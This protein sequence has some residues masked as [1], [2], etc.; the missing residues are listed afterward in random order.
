M[1]VVLAKLGNPE[2]V[3]RFALAFAVTAPVIMFA[4]LQLRA[5]QAT[6][7]KEDYSFGQYFALRIV[8]AVVALLVIAGIAAFSGY[9]REAVWV[10]AAVGLAKTFESISDVIHG[11]AQQHERM[12]RIAISLSIKG[13]ISLLALGAVTYLT[14]SLVAGCLALAAAW[15]TVL[16]VYDLRI[17]PDMLVGRH[18]SRRTRRSTLRP[19]WNAH[20]LWRLAFLSLPL[21]LTMMLISL[22]ANIPRYFVEGFRGERQLGIFAAMS[23]LMVAGNTVVAALGQSASPRMAHH[24][25]DRDKKAFTLL[26]AR[27][28]GMGAVV[29]IAGMLVAAVAGRWLLTVFYSAEYAREI[30]AFVWI[31]AATGLSYVQSFLGCAMTA[32]RCF[33]VQ[34]PLLGASALVTAGLCYFLVHAWGILGAAIAIASATGALT[35]G[36]L[37]IVLLAIRRM[38]DGGRSGD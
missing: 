12:N 8:T 37:L 24:F 10:I 17:V 20:V 30:G 32:T 23:Y 3:G 9:Q 33:R 35:L 34:V 16:L 13:P 28:C 27:L 4:N 26:L 21:G 18:R 11:L 15:A 36:S 2:M 5:V 29:G 1:L 38:D 7:A 31:A 14:G 19:D 25:A 6:D 22:N